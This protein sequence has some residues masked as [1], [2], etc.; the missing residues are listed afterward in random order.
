LR[1]S[2]KIK[3]PIIIA[4]GLLNCHKP[5]KKKNKNTIGNINIKNTNMITNIIFI[6][7]SIN[8]SLLS[9]VI[10][11]RTLKSMVACVRTTF[12][13][14]MFAEYH[15]KRIVTEN[16]YV[17][18]LDIKILNAAVAWHFTGSVGHCSSTP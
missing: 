10:A 16:W 11:V 1:I 7:S 9:Y 12:T 13:S 6:A 15:L 2:S 4:T 3:T 18:I 8:A 14:A 5:Y 17:W